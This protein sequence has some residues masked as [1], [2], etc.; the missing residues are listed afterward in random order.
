[1][2]KIEIYL[3][4]G[5]V[6]T[7]EVESWAKAQEILR[8][9][10]TLGYTRWTGRVWEHFPPHRIRKITFTGTDPGGPLDALRI[11]ALQE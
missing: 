10:S 3:D 7:R 5:R 8:D 2:T 9:A 1:M 11:S 6:F 4:D